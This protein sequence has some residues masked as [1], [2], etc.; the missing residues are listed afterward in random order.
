MSL[1]Q[2]EG[3]V[4][5]D[6]TRATLAFITY[7]RSLFSSK[8]KPFLVTIARSAKDGFFPNEKL[9]NNYQRV[10]LENIHNELCGMKSFRPDTGAY[11]KCCPKCKC[12]IIYDYGKFEG[13][14]EYSP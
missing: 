14:F 1:P 12:E 4:D 3:S 13:V 11:F 7:M 10:I 5:I 2:S 9:A 6:A 8:N